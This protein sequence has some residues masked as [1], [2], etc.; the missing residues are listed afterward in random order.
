MAYK[1]QVID[2]ELRGVSEIINSK[3]SRR[4]TQYFK[5]LNNLSAVEIGAFETQKMRDSRVLFQKR[6]EGIRQVLKVRTTDQEERHGILTDK[7]LYITDLSGDNLPL[8]ST[9]QQTYNI[10]LSLIH[11]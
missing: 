2:L 8:L 6:Q 1:D 3:V 11:I 5:N 7:S 10:D 9:P 4:A